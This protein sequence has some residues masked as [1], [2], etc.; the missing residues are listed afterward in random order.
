MLPPRED[1]TDWLGAIVERDGLGVLLQALIKSVGRE[2]FMAAVEAA[3]DDRGWGSE[4]VIT[5]D[6]GQQVG[7][8]CPPLSARPPTAHWQVQW[9]GSW[10]APSPARSTGSSVGTAMLTSPASRQGEQRGPVDAGYFHGTC[11]HCEPDFGREDE[12]CAARS[13]LESLSLDMQIREEQM[14]DEEEARA[15]CARSEHDAGA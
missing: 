5:G 3:C 12:T 4:P 8:Q 9:E 13:V 2:C 7:L 11:W 1:L 15:P 10:V 14:H 6:S